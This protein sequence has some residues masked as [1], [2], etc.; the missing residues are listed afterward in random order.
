M[1]VEIGFQLASG[2]SSLL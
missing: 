1:N 2:T